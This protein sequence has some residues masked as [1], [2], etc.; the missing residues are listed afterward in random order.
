TGAK[1]VGVRMNE[2]EALGFLESV[3][4]GILAT[5][6]ADGS[7]ALT[8]LWFVVLDGDVFVRTLAASRKAEHL[9]RDPRVSFLV[10][11][12]L[13]WAELKAVVVYGRAQIETD[14]EL[15]ARVDAALESK[16]EGFRMPAAAPSK[17][18]G[19][20]A[21]ERVYVRIVPERANLTWDNSKL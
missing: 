13:A 11:S 12:G 2:G 9:R 7:P 10:E 17:T 6:R 15:T 1:P 4:T 21:A 8:P 19:H 5:L 18:K 3:H 20:Y 14:P 16:Y